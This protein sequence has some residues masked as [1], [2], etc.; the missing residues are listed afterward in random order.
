MVMVFC[1]YSQKPHD[2]SR[3]RA[4]IAYLFWIVS[5]PTLTSSMDAADDGASTGAY[6]YIQGN[7]VHCV[8][9]EEY[10]SRKVLDNVASQVDVLDVFP[11][12]LHLKK[13]LLYLLN[14]PSLSDAEANG[15]V[16]GTSLEEETPEDAGD[17]G[18]L[19]HALYFPKYVLNLQENL[20]NGFVELKK[21]LAKVMLW[22]IN[23]QVTVSRLT[24]GITN[25]LLKCCHMP[26]GVQLLCRVYGHGTNLIIDRHREFVSQLHLNALGLA[27]AVHCRFKNGVIYGFFPGRSL[28]PEE[29]P[30]PHIYPLVAEQLGIWHLRIDTH[31]IEVGVAKVRQFLKKKDHKKKDGKRKPKKRFISNVWELIEEWIEIVPVRPELVKL[32]A[33]HLPNEQVLDATIKE[34]IAKEFA[35]LK[36]T[37]TT[38]ALPVVLCHCDLLL[39]NVIIPA[40]YEIADALAPVP[41]LPKPQDNQ[42][43]FIDYEYMLPAPRAFDIA[44]HLAEWQGFDC[45]R[46]AIPTPSKKNPVMRQFVRG[47]LQGVAT[48]SDID[49]LIDEIQAFYGLPGFYWGIWAMIQL[50]ISNI[51]FEYA[52]YAAERLEEYWLW[53]R[54]YIK[55]PS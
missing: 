27:P 12:K 47:Y 9:L 32:F 48:D 54:A 1:H 26:L 34:V 10:N 38:I 41:P 30:N 20:D 51:D 45:N 31:L 24:G 4:A 43:K 18:E 7:Q 39:G 37:L 11:N 36:L 33:D 6:C 16:L 5:L 52:K 2:R 25:M 40:N 14:N 3:S 13:N 8:P 35:W 22:D 49:E 53:K 44:N 28:T 23:D 19:S 29:L 42:I 50:E 46:D 17:R 55:P 15:L 21:L